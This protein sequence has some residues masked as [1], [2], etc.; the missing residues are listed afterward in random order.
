MTKDTQVV[1]LAVIV[2]VVVIIDHHKRQAAAQPV[3]VSIMAPPSQGAPMAGTFIGS[4][5]ISAS[6]ST[7]Q[8][9]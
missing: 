3:T 7:A 1:V 9:L 6:P 5:A 2:G 4:N 8:Y